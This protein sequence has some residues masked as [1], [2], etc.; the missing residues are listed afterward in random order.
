MG[1]KC[2][3]N[4]GIVIC[5]YFGIQHDQ[6]SAVAKTVNF[7]NRLCDYVG[8]SGHINIS[9][10]TKNNLDS[11]FIITYVGKK[12]IHNMGKHDVFEVIHKYDN[13][14]NKQL[15]NGY[16]KITAWKLPNRISIKKSNYIYVSFFGSVNIGYLSLEIKDDSGEFEYFLDPRSISYTEEDNGILS[17][18]NQLYSNTWSFKV[19]NTKLKP[20]KVYCRNWNL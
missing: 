15:E 4:T 18:T 19:T 20:G 2:G 7:A 1:L 11:K 3:I 14:P 5:G 17:F 8:E 13:N 10:T 9:T 12:E 6:F 16:G